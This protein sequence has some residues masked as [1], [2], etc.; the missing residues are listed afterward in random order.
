MA[1]TAV[2]DKS[3]I[4]LRF[5]ITFRSP[6]SFPI[7]PPAQTCS[8]L[9][10]SWAGRS[11]TPEMPGKLRLGFILTEFSYE[12]L[13]CASELFVMCTLLLFAAL[14]ILGNFGGIGVRA[15]Q[16]LSSFLKRRARVSAQVTNVWANW[17]STLPISTATKLLNVAQ[18]CV[19][20]EHAFARQNLFVWQITNFSNC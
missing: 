2:R 14:K 17:L 4:Y 9:A 3:P 19:N 12:F 10:P 7:S 15:A 13:R 6:R 5:E 20:Y 1:A 8:S 11:P 16:K 18:F